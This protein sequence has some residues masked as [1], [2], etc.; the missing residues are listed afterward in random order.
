[1]ASPIDDTDKVIACVQ[2]VKD[3]VQSV[4]EF[5]N[6]MVFVYDQKDAADKL[7][8]LRTFPA[9]AIVYEGMR[10]SETSSPVQHS[11][12][13]MGSSVTLVTSIMIV[14]Q[15]DGGLIKVDNRVSVMNLLGK[16]RRQM[17][18]RR[19]PSGHY[20]KFVVEAEAAPANGLVFWIQRW[21]TPLQLQHGPV[22]G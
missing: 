15:G 14:D 16:V 3:A 7:K 5:A 1:M 13:R 9:A 4:A 10:V 22:K 21:Q 19:S 18:D 12:G 11:S 6:R 17:L 8:G 20:W 2:D